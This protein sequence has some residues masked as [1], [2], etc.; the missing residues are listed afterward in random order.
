MLLK[1]Q[2]SKEYCFIQFVL[3]FYAINNLVI[4]KTSKKMSINKEIHEV[5]CCDV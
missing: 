3:G 2:I 1:F 4:R 5:C